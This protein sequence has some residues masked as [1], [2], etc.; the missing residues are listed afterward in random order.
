MHGTR[1]KANDSFRS[2]QRKFLTWYFKSFVTYYPM[3]DDVLE[4]STKC[5][6][7]LVVNLISRIFEISDD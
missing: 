7:K 3:T 4:N 6:K 5:T 1:T 2:V